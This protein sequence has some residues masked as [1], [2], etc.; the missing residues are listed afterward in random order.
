MAR[1]ALRGVVV[2]AAATAVVMSVTAVVINLATEWKWNFWA[3]V[4]VAAATALVAGVTVWRDRRSSA[5]GPSDDE[6]AGGQVVDHSRIDGDNIQIGRA[7]YV[8]IGRR[9]DQKK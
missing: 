7:H 3:W 8:H 5:A 1:R 4:A 2:P 6:G 9:R